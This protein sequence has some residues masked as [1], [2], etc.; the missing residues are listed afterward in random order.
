MKKFRKILALVL[1]ALLSLTLCACESNAEKMAKL[2]GTYTM[3]VTAEEDEVAELLEL[4]EA[5]DE[6]I[7]LVDMDS[8]Q[9][10]QIVSFDTDGNY[11][12]AYDVDATLENTRDFYEG[13]MKALY[14]GRTTLNDVYDYSFDDV[15]EDEFYQLYAD[16]YSCDDYEDMIDSF[17]EYSYDLDVLSEPWETGTYTIRAGQIY[18][19]M[20]GD[21]EELALGYRLDG[22]SLTL[23]YSDAEEVYTKVN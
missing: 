21:D 4:I 23:I 19:T 14:E 20:T 13:Y 22:D 12:Y 15:T 10:V 3:S 2:A 5:Y 1:V 11:Y 6:E 9:Y 16:M 8:L 17:V 18:C 7:A